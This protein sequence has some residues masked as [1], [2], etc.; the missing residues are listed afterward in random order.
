MPTFGEQ[1][2]LLHPDSARLLE[3]WTGWRGDRPAPKRSDA[4][5]RELCPLLPCIMLLER[6][7]VRP[8]FTF[9]LAGTALRR[10]TGRE[11]TGTDFSQIWDPADRERINHALSETLSAYDPHAF[12]AKGVSASGRTASFECVFLPMLVDGRQTVQVL[13]ALFPLN[14]PHWFS[15]HPI[16]NFRT[17][18][19]ETRDI[20]ALDRINQLVSGA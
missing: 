12:L 6:S 16:T 4:K 20:G 14:E 15:E 10:F 7:P 5:M 11:L 1:T 19:D 2:D 17:G 8:L 3:L 13:G 18:S 9:R